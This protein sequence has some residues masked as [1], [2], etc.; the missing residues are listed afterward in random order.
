MRSLGHILGMSLAP[1][2]AR[3]ERSGAGIGELPRDLHSY[4][5]GDAWPHVGR[6]LQFEQGAWTVTDNLPKTLPVT[7]AEIDVV[8]GWLGD[9]FD[10][11]FGDRP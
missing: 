3:L 2:V 5:H 4:M 7:S 8:E 10:Q 11:L 1:K 6:P 9:V